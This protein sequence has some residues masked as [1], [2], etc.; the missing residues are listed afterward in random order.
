MKRL[1]YF[2][3]L[4]PLFGFVVVAIALFP[5]LVFY[6]DADSIPYPVAVMAALI[7]AYPLG[8]APA[9]LTGLLD[10]LLRRVPFRLLLSAACGAVV[11]VKLFAVV[12]LP[13]F[14]NGWDIWVFASTGALSAALCSWL[15]DRL[16]I[17]PSPLELY[18]KREM[19]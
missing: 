13:V 4:G 11:T 18:P 5:A 19:H 14:G 10:L 12:L 15:S 9:L 16:P 3:F 17:Q 2:V 8:I 7:F 1:A 6:G